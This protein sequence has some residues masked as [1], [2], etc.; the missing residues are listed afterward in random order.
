MF[1]IN[2]DKFQGPFDLI[3]DLLAKKKLE[4]SE[5]RI[6]DIINEYINYIENM[7]IDADVQGDFLVVASRLLELKSKF[8]LSINSE[9]EDDDMERLVKSLEIYKFYKGVAESLRNR[10]NFYGDLYFRKPNEHFISKIINIEKLTL[11]SIKEYSLIFNR[12]IDT[13][14]AKIHSR[15]IISVEDKINEIELILKSKNII[16]FTEVAKSQEK[17][18]SIATLLSILE[19]AKIE[20][21]GIKQYDLFNE[22][23]I[24]RK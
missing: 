18:D 3:L 9:E 24:E 22:I 17:D 2:I 1:Q 8:L 12:R 13:D 23:I 4:I 10:E 7:R 6:I 14:K 11:N 19:L 16:Y 21:V 15:K 5:I 20:R